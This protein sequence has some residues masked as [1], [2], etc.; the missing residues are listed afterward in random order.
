MVQLVDLA[1]CEADLVAVG[2]IAGCCGGDQLAL[3]QLALK[4]FGHRNR[5]VCRAGHAHCLVDV[6]AAGQGIADGSADAGC[7]AAE[8]LDFRGMVVGFVFEEIEPV[9]FFAIDV[10]LDF[11]GA[12]VD[13]LGFVEVFQDALGFEPLGADSAHVH[14]ADGFLVAAELVA[15]GEVLLERGL[16]GF[17]VDLHVLKNGAEGSVAAVIGPIGVDHLDFGDGGIALLVFG[18]VFLAE[19]DVGLVHGESALGDEGG[20]ACLVKLA[21]A[22]DDLDGFRRRM[23]HFE[24]IALF[25]GCFARF[26]RIDDVMLD[27]GNVFVGE[28][29]FEHVDFGA[30]DL[31]ALPLA[32]ELNAL[33]CRSGA[34]VELAG[35]GFD[36]ENN[37]AFCGGQFGKRIVGLRLA[38]NGGNALLEQLVACALNV[39]AVDETDAREA[40]DAEDGAQLVQE[41][42][43]LDVEAGLLL[44]VNTRNH[45]FP[46]FPES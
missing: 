45:G 11:D 21:E 16:Y 6:A 2:R 43:R 8:G 23:R 42:M 7:R 29:A 33:A 4:R 5:G 27:G 37:R 20:K 34:L 35:Q 17:V 31:G 15:H 36:G 10:A 40:F 38:E 9:L 13:F 32:D 46:A 24:R 14:E 19:G 30:Q 22:F 39:V 3:G 41:L 25:E 12:G 1:G 28:I 26:D 44:N 18:E